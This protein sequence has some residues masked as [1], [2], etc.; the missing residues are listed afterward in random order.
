MAQSGYRWAFGDFDSAT[1]RSLK[2]KRSMGMLYGTVSVFTVAG[3]SEGR[4]QYQERIDLSD[5]R[6]DNVS[7]A[8]PAEREKPYRDLFAHQDKLDW[9]GNN[10]LGIDAEKQWRA[11]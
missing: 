11:D 2:Y 9:I 5:F 6:S 7:L 1:A 4:V 10:I 8:L 3:G